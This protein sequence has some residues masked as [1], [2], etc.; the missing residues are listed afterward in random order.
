VQQGR[1]AV[2]L[3]AV[4]VWACR[5]E[6]PSVTHA[7]NANTAARA[8]SKGGAPGTH[9]AP[10]SSEALPSQNPIAAPARDTDGPVA[11][12]ARVAHTLQEQSVRLQA[13]KGR[14][15]LLLALAPASK[16]KLS[17][18]SPSEANSPLA[19]DLAPPCYVLVWNAPPPRLPGGR[20]ESGGLPIGSVGEVMAWKYPTAS[21]TTVLAVI[22]DPVL[23]S[24]PTDEL[25]E[26]RKAQK[27]RCAGSLQGVKLTAAGATLS[28]KRAQASVYCVETA[29]D[30][31]DFWMLAHD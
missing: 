26:T 11:E 1:G 9:S 12:M 8:S 16:A 6:N 3:C 18:E 2:V 4:A 21:G 22:G 13:S 17:A 31:K 30:E 20:S 25:H 28:P 15:E 27:F 29:L 5:P 19:L 24:G 7:S 14:C 10:T 23:P